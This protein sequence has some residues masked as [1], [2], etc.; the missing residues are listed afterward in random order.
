MASTITRTKTIRIANG[1]ADYFEDKPLNR[2]VECVHD[3]MT[4]GKAE[5]DGQRLKFSSEMSVDTAKMNDTTLAEIEEMVNLCGG[6]LKEFLED[7]CRGL[8][9]GTLVIDDGKLA[10]PDVNTDRFSQVCRG[11]C[12][13]PQSVLEKATEA[14]ERGM[15]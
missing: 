1:T 4:S 11:K 14:V 9:E 13:D 12:L 3:M 6:T 7:V 2:I 15:L 8:N 10:M 5:F